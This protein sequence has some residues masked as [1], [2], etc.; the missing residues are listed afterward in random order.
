[1]IYLQAALLVTFITVL[2]T[3]MRV[4]LDRFLDDDDNDG[5]SF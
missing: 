3:V 5:S 2:I 4:F 1:M